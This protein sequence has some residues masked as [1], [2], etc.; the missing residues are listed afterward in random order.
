MPTVE[1]QR[2][3]PQF[4][5]VLVGSEIE[6]LLGFGIHMTRQ[7]ARESCGRCTRHPRIL[8][9]CESRRPGEQMHML[10]RALIEDIVAAGKWVDVGREPAAYRRGLGVR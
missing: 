2:P 1:I 5:D 3:T 9:P 10:V 7:R 6:K 4:I 8:R